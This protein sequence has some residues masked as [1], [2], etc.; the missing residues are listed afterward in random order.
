L[1]LEI[2]DPKIILDMYNKAKRLYLE[3]AKN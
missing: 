1:L 3:K 2:D